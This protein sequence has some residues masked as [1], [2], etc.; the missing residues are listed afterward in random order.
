M[1][2]T[3]RKVILSEVTQTQ[4]Y[5]P[6]IYLFIVDISC[7]VKDNYITIHRQRN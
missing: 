2:K 4:K 1:D 3:R 5:K 6:C 7:K